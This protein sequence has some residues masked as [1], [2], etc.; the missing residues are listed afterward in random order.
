MNAAASFFARFAC[1]FLSLSVVSCKDFN[2]TQVQA[3]KR[4]LEAKMAALSAES[5]D[6]DQKLQALREKLPPS[7]ATTQ[8]ASK[9]VGLLEQN[10]KMGEQE[11][12]KAIQSYEA[13]NAAV[14]ALEAELASLRARP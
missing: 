1:V 4:E 3:Q 5:Q 12:S 14:K 11:L 6:L 13:T 2:Y 10:L 7:V 9:Q 8:L